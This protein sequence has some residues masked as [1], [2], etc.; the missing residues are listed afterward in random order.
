MFKT[1][2]CIKTMCGWGNMSEKKQK[3]KRSVGRLYKKSAPLRRQEIRHP[4]KT[5]DT[6]RSSIH[7]VTAAEAMNILHSY[8]LG[9][10]S[11]EAARRLVE[12]GNNTIEHI[13]R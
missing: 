11:A 7:T 3:Q 12:F 9:L 5:S 4:R 13:Q 1:V 2:E 8:P 10:G 6:S